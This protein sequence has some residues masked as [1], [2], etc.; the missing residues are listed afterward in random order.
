MPIPGNNPLDTISAIHSAPGAAVAFMA[1]D[2]IGEMQTVG[3]W[4]VADLERK[5]ATLEPLFSG[6]FYFSINSVALGA[7]LKNGLKYALRDHIRSLNAVYVDID[8]YRVG[9][10]PETALQGVCDAVCEGK[11]PQPSMIARSGRG[12]Y[13]L[14]LLRDDAG[15]EPPAATALSIEKHGAVCKAIVERTRHLGA[16]GAATD[17]AR[18]LRVPESIN[19]KSGSEVSWN[20][21]RDVDGSNFTHSL[22]YLCRFF[23]VC[24]SPRGGTYGRQILAPGSAPKRAAGAIEKHR[25]CALDIEKLEAARG[26]WKQGSRWFSLKR[27]VQIL[28]GTGLK[29]DEVFERVEAMAARCQP[30]FPSDAGDGTIAQIVA[31]AFEG[32]I[33]NA[34]VSSLLALFKVSD[35]DA[36]QLE[37]QT[38]VPDSVKD[39]RK[40]EAEANGHQARKAARQHAIRAHIEANPSAS[41]SDVQIALSADG[42]EASAATIKRELAQLFPSRT[43]AKAGRKPAPETAHPTPQQ[44]ETPDSLLSS[45]SSL[46]S[47]S[48]HFEPI[49]FAPEIEAPFLA[50]LTDFNHAN[51]LH[52]A[53]SLAGN[54]SVFVRGRD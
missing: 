44:P 52:S 53:A 48:K 30:A 36:R 25:R 13:V 9:I 11:L 37:L 35:A 16:D 39:A 47:L 2:D 12:I 41:A 27:Y 40:A 26:G 46:L 54:R 42:I 29:R 18:V 20:F 31:S 49:E 8:C 32:R 51:E 38:I 33:V 1:K 6:D 7:T 15:T 10:E 21:C 17:A 24:E 28:R 5:A 19:Y 4:A 34:A 50:P 14:W 22:D 45:L 3:G 23:G 43:K